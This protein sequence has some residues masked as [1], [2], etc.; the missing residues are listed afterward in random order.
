[1]MEQNEP[2]AQQVGCY[3]NN[4]SRTL[5]VYD[6]FENA[7]AMGFHL[8]T[9]AAHHF[10]S[11][12]EVATPGEFLFCGDVPEPLQQATQQMGLQAV[13]APKIAGFQRELVA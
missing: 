1:M 6:L 3:F 8:S 12:L 7:D 4:A 9:T 13:F 11:L 10:P 2:G 5:V